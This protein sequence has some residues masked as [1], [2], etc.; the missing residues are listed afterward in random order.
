MNISYKEFE[1]HM[2]DIQHDYEYYE[3]VCDAV[4]SDFMYENLRCAGLAI[5]LLAQM[6]EDDDD[7]IG[8]FIFELDWGKDYEP[9][10]LTDKNNE[11]IPLAT[12]RDLYNVL[13]GA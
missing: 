3:K 1:Q 6:M 4:N 5:D 9:G 13:T 2:L 10:C 8:Y 12:L 7:L 11:D